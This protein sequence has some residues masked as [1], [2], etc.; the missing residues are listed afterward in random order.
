M[1]AGVGTAFAAP[2]RATLQFDATPARV[3]QGVFEE[4]AMRTLP[5]VALAL[6]SGAAIVTFVGCGS[7][8]NPDI[9]SDAGDESVVVNPPPPPPNPPPPPADGGVQDADVGD[10]IID[11][12]RD[13]D[14]NIMCTAKGD[15][16]TTSAQ[17]CT[18]NCAAS[19]DGGL[20]CADPITLCKQPGVACTLGNECC[21]GSCVSGTCSSVLCEPD[22]LSCALASDCCSQNCVAQ[23]GGGGK[24][25]TL[26]PTGKP[27]SGSP[28]TTN[29]QCA[30]TWCNNGVCANPSFCVLNGDICSTDTECCGGFCTKVGG[31]SVGYC[32]TAPANVTNCNVAGSLCGAGADAGADGGGTACDTTCCSHSCGPYITS[33]TICEPP[34]GCKPT[35]ELC[36]TDNDCCGAPPSK[37]NVHCRKT[38]AAQTF[39]R[40]DNGNSCVAPGAECKTGGLTSCSLPNNC[41]EPHTLLAD[42]GVGPLQPSSYCNN[43]PANCCRQDVLGIPRCLFVSSDC[44]NPVPNGTA[45][46]SSADCCGKPCVGGVC[47]TT[48]VGSGGACTS[49]SDCCPG[50]PCAIPPGGTTGI[51]GGTVLADGGVSD[52]APPGTDGGVVTQDAGYDGGDSGSVSVCALY[53]QSC[54]QNSDCCNGVPCD[55]AG[56]H[57]CH[58]N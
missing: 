38:N 22:G 54:T 16:C 31:S 10:V 52:A 34:G 6:M 51:C 41:C 46:A 12:S 8:S 32:S 20:A 27:T 15:S 39:G 40:C 45:C 13:P 28:C 21:T 3:G 36:K 56:T 33:A 14:A 37:S 24:C 48:C 23:A 19:A 43:T 17:C 18:A 29:S 9:P 58:F 50:L 7:D 1:R 53:G 44:T 47:G 2:A 11:G 42:G 4:D 55:T 5:W 49:T 35:G 57:T 30:S 26:S 25:Q